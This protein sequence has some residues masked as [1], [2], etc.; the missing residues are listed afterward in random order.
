MSM[1]KQIISLSIAIVLFST[2][3]I[4]PTVLASEDGTTLPNSSVGTTRSTV[5]NRDYLQLYRQMKQKLFEKDLKQKTEV[6][7][8]QRKS[9]TQNI[10]TYQQSRQKQ[11]VELRKSCYPV[12]SATSSA[13]RK[14]L[15]DACKQK[16]QAFELETKAKITQMRSSCK[17]IEKKVLGITDS[18]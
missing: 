2:L 4:S 1:S 8:Q 11:Q 9:C 17:Q 18:M 7:G 16:I 10:L 12:E 6:V 5:D 14:P 13:I 15:L 3:F